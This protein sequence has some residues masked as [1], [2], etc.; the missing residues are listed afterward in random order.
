MERLKR[1]SDFR[2]AAQA[3]TGQGARAHASAFILQAR[4]RAPVGAPRVG[5]TVSKQVGNA[6]ER[7]RV[8]RRLRELVRLAPPAALCPG[9]DY[10]LIGR[11]AALKAP[12]GDMMKELSGALRRVHAS[13]AARAATGA[14]GDRPP[15]RAGS[16]SRRQTPKPDKPQTDKY[17]H[18]KYEH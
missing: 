4:A 8:R 9:H 17:E 1:R 3:A 13:S 10:V 5:F 14:A 2:A 6:V 16:S 11:R 15:H 18:C 7:N 12:F